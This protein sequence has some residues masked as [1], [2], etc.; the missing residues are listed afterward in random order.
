MHFKTA[1][2]HM[3]ARVI[4]LVGAADLLENKNLADILKAAAGKL[5]QA[6]EHADCEAVD[7]A[8]KAHMDARDAAEAPTQQQ[9]APAFDPS[10]GTAPTQ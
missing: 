8:T 6:S 2:L 9:P 3:H 10:K 7:A 1:I 5:S 4:E